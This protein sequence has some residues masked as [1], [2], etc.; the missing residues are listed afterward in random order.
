MSLSFP[1]ACTL[2]GERGLQLPGPLSSFTVA[3]SHNTMGS[4][5]LFLDAFKPWLLEA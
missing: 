5:V 3:D 1:N 4:L 2:G